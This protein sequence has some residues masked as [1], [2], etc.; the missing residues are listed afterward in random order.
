MII[1]CLG[2][3]A[4]KEPSLFL[5]TELVPTQLAEN[6]SNGPNVRPAH[7][8][9]EK[10]PRVV[11]LRHAA[12]QSC[13]VQAECRVLRSWGACTPTMSPRHNRPLITHN[14]IQHVGY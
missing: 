7:I 6:S 9:W 2:E 3:A 8:P 4:K 12:E 10:S 1:S 13:W 5:Q 14:G 11:T